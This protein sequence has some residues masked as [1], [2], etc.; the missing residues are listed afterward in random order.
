MTDASS[1]SAAVN[2]GSSRQQEVINWLLQQPDIKLEGVEVANAPGM[3]GG[4][5][6]YVKKEASIKIRAYNTVRPEM[7]S[8]FSNRR[9]MIELYPK[10]RQFDTVPIFW[11][12]EEKSWLKGSTVFAATR[13]RMQQLKSEYKL[14]RY[15][16]NDPEVS[17]KKFLFVRLCVGSRCF[18]LTLEKGAKSQ[19]ACMPIA[20]MPNHDVVPDAGWTF[21][22]S[23]KAFVM[24]AK[25]P[26]AA[27]KQVFISYGRKPNCDLLLHYGFCLASNLRDSV[28][29]DVQL[30]K[31]ETKRLSISRHGQQIPTISFS[32]LRM[33]MCILGHGEQDAKAILA[34]CVRQRMKK[35]VEDHKKSSHRKE[36]NDNEEE[37]KGGGV[38][39]EEEEDTYDQNEVG[40]EGEESEDDIIG[41]GFN[42]N[43]GGMLNVKNGDNNNA[44]EDCNEDN[45]TDDAR[46]QGAFE[47][48]TRSDDSFE[49]VNDDEAIGKR[50]KHRRSTKAWGRVSAGSE[51]K[52]PHTLRALLALPISSFKD[53]R[54]GCISVE[55]EI[56]VLAA[57]RDACKEALQR[58]P[59]TLEEDKK[60][61]DKLQGTGEG[62]G[63]EGGREEKQHS[64]SFIKH[65]FAVRLRMGEKRVLKWHMD[66]Y[67]LAV[68]LLKGGGDSLLK[69]EDLCKIE[70]Y[71]R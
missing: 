14:V 58:Y 35:N 29:I 42:E 66:L 17:F 61:R 23:S 1:S 64:G 41:D 27:G 18:G 69:E 19:S 13:K 4:R 31:S 22:T 36:D 10:L 67:D 59:T 50:R 62:E 55:N 3:E 43:E 48:S 47:R 20:D 30:G 40:E 6:I 71:K 37:E 26:L 12:R 24:S 52:I 45:D 53:I 65:L 25:R 39:G 8:V 44:I 21:D 70:M 46:Q 49:N 5:G 7:S 28:Q 2:C 11:N 54:C 63:G 60:I 57:I 33:A 56:G 34:K 38:E 32:I 15:L 68:R 9:H 16:W 51:L